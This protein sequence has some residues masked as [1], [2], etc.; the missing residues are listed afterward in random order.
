MFFHACTLQKNTHTHMYAKHSYERTN[1]NVLYIQCW[2][3]SGLPVT[4]EIDY[5]H[6]FQKKKLSIYLT[7][8]VT[9]LLQTR[10]FTTPY[11]F[12]RDFVQYPYG[13]TH[14]CWHCETPCF[15]ITLW[16]KVLVLKFN[17][18]AS[19]KYSTNKT[20]KIYFG[21]KFQNTYHSRK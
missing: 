19:I 17:T 20:Q 6:I 11:M 13:Y 14:M 3:L 10:T 4:K 18:S 5:T 7:P 12:F 9:A 16:K 1:Y 21:V 8:P 15:Q 2:Y